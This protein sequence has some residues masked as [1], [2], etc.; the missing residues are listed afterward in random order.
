M[1]T[2]MSDPQLVLT[3]PATWRNDP[4]GAQRALALFSATCCSGSS[5]NQREAVLERLTCEVIARVHIPG[6][7]PLADWYGELFDAALLVMQEYAD[8]RLSG[9]EPHHAD[10]RASIIVLDAWQRTRNI[11]SR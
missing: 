8:I 5:W 10:Q 1:S 11:W 7:K 6:S 3:I 4:R 9:S 2:S